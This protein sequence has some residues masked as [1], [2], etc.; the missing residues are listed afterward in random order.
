MPFKVTF[1]GAGSIEFSRKLLSDLLSVPEFK[2]TEVAFTDINEENVD[3]A[4]KLCQ[5]DIDINGID[6]KIQSTT[7]WRI[8]LKNA[9]YMFN[10]VRIGGLEAFKTDVEIPLKYGVNQCVGDTLNAGGIM[11]GLRGIAENLKF[12]QRHSRGFS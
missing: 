12:L 8:A 1:I 9:K 5:R 11:Y 4:T 10:V 7:D 6:I 2:N 3:M